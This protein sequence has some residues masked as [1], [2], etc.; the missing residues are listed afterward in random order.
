VRST[1]AAAA[2]ATRR[3]GRPR[4]L[5]V[6]ALGIGQ[7][8]AWGSTF[9]LLTVLAGP[10]S[11]DTGWPGAFVVGGV[12]AALLAAAAVS[13]A[14]GNLIGRGHG[15]HVLVASAAI[16]AAGLAALSAATN[17]P[18]YLLSWAVLGLGMGAG[19]YGP[20]FSFLGQLYGESARSAITALTLYGG[21]AS[22]VCWPLSALLVER[23]GWRGTCLAYAAAHLL[24]T[25][26]LYAAALPRRTAPHPVEATTETAPEKGA[27]TA[28][29]PAVR[30]GDAFAVALVAGIAVVSTT[31][32]TAMS[33]HMLTLL[34]GLGLAAPAAVLL[35]AAIGPSQVAARVLEFLSGA[36]HHPLW[37]LL[38]AMAALAAATTIMGA[39]GAASLAL[40]ACYGAGIGLA[41]IGNGT[42]PL[43]VFGKERYARLMG[44]IALVALP[45]QAAAPLLGAALID[46]LGERGTL[47]ALGAL[48]LSALGMSVGLLR[49]ERVRGLRR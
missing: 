23:L 18:L 2:T 43:A 47:L 26:P 17:P 5:V 30:P 36:R 31:V 13:P 15:R 20:A 9:Y 49:R 22:T 7:I 29:R 28:A 14:V 44:R 1:A 42:A 19:L 37:T 24:I 41:S 6:G 11:A 35:A 34:Q 46:G 16:L 32:S 3:G 40:I 21:F 39:A 8:L 27:P 25:L 38:A 33:V 45:A 12:S 4:P 10:V 48:A